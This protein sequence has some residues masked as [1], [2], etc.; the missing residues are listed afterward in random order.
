MAG[1][2]FKRSTQGKELVQHSVSDKTLAEECGA[3][4]SKLAADSQHVE[5][6]TA[7]LEVILIE[8]RDFALRRK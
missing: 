3:S 1:G 8:L 5:E 2:K 6:S 4:A 7:N